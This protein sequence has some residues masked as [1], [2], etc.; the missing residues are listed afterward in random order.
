MSKVWWE[1]VFQMYKQFIGTN[2]TEPVYRR[3]AAVMVFHKRECAGAEP[4]DK[5]INLTQQWFD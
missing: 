4:A 2:I 5:V 1:F 3:N